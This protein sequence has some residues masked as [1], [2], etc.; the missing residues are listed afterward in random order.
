MVLD[1][2]FGHFSGTPQNI[3]V[4]AWALEISSRGFHELRTIKPLVF[5]GLE[6]LGN[7]DGTEVNCRK[8]ATESTLLPGW[9]HVEPTWN[10]AGTKVNCRK[11]GTESTLLSS[12]PTWRHVEPTWNQAGTKSNFRKPHTESTLPLL[13]RSCPVFFYN[14]K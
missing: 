9:N 14:T 7:Q 1:I 11:P 3:I 4:I 6:A 8:P 12:L 2:R 5:K 13:A 10:Q